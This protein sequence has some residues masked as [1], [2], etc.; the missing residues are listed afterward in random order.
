[1]R[2]RGGADRPL[3]SSSVYLDGIDWATDLNPDDW[4]HYVSAEVR[5]LWQSFT[6][7]QKLATA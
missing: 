6:Y 3:R 4:R 1:M 7:E 2:T 5:G